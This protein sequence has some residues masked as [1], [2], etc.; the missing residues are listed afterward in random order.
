[1]DHRLAVAAEEQSQSTLH[2]SNNLRFAAFFY[3]D[4]DDRCK[5]L[6]LLTVVV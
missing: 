6:V 2:T 5:S 4:Y 3:W 1:M